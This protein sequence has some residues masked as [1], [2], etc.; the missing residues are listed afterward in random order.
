M[1]LQNLNLGS[2]IKYLPQLVLCRGTKS[3]VFVA[4][5]SM[6]LMEAMWQF[7]LHPLGCLQILLIPGRL[8][9]PCE[10]YSD[11]AQLLYF[12]RARSSCLGILLPVAVAVAK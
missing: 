7:V 5:D 8:S 10:G 11:C 2:A 12:V 4:A 9:V 6:L 3:L 1:F